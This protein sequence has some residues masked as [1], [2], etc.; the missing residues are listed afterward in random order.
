MAV[1]ALAAAALGLEIAF[2]RLL[3]ALFVTNLV[4]ALLSTALLGL[5]CG[6]AAA[7]ARRSWRGT[8]ARAFASSVAALLAAAAVPATLAAAVLGQPLLALAALAAAFTAIGWTL[9]ASF[10][11]EPHRASA[12]YRVDLSAAAAAALATPLALDAFGGLGG[13]IAAGLPLTVAAW[14]LRPPGRFAG[15]L[16]ASIA[17]IVLATA[18]G[19]G[20]LTVDPGALATAKPLRALLRAGAEITAT[21]WDAFA[22]TDR[23]RTADGAVYL[24]ADG[25][26]G[27]LIPGPEAERWERA[28]AGFAFVAGARERVFLIGSGGGLDAALAARYGANDIVAIELNA[29]GVA[30]TDALVDGGYPAGTDLRLGEG[31]RELA[32]ERARGEEQR[33]VGESQGARFA[34]RRLVDRLVMR[35][36]GMQSA[37]AVE[38][39]FHFHFDQGAPQVF[40]QLGKSSAQVQAVLRL[41]ADRHVKLAGFV[42]LFFPGQLFQSFII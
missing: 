14:A 28:V 41:V 12:L 7:S 26:A 8:T 39:G 9:T 20:A 1:A 24:F 31:R 40:P 15:P 6:A 38:L 5:G 35:E 33:D 42:V 16:V 19:T 36:Q 25:A 27:S 3:S 13:S 30:L 10:A 23:V 4:G 22:R 34:H 2:A 11:A 18:H 21:R 37:R 17:G 32:R 29:A